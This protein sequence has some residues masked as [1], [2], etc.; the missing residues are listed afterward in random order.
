MC[1]VN[2]YNLV[3]LLFLIDLGN[4]EEYY[5]LLGS[6]TYKVFSHLPSPMFYMLCKRE[7]AV[8]TVF[9]VGKQVQRG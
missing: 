8:S 9:Q 7:R 5:C 1:S 4:T 2:L 3:R 6:H